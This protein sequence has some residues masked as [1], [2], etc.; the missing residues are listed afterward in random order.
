ML[1]STNYSGTF[2]I[3]IQLLLI[4]MVHVV[5]VRA[6]QV[7]QRRTRFT[8][9]SFRDEAVK[10]MKKLLCFQKWIELYQSCRTFLLRI[11]RNN[12]NFVNFN[13]NGRW[14]LKLLTV[15]LKNWVSE[16]SQNDLHPSIFRITTIMP[17]IKYSAFSL[18][19]HNFMTIW[20]PWFSYMLN[21][22][23]QFFWV[24][25]VWIYNSKYRPAWWI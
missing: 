11:A 13:Y 12:H 6:T 16:M 21:D 2:F 18:T 7:G 9:L 14:R 3:Y 10:V 15:W 4:T 22:L 17:L 23:E 5:R 1:F 25:H 24:T 8:F 19:F 20:M